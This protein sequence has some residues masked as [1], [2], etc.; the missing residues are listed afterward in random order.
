MRIIY[1]ATICFFGSIEC[2]NTL[3]KFLKLCK[4]SEPLDHEKNC[5]VYDEILSL[6]QNGA[7]AEIR[8]IVM[9]EE[10]CSRLCDKKYVRLDILIIALMVSDNSFYRRYF[11]IIKSLPQSAFE[12]CKNE[13]LTIKALE[14][15]IITANIFLKINSIKRLTETFLSLQQKADTAINSYKEALRRKADYFYIYLGLESVLYR[16]LNDPRDTLFCLQLTDEPRMFYKF[17]L[18]VKNHT[19]FIFECDVKRRVMMQE[20]IKKLLLQKYFTI[21]RSLN[22]VLRV[23]A[24]VNIKQRDEYSKMLNKYISI[25]NFS[26]EALE[27]C[28]NLKNDEKYDSQ[29]VLLVKIL[30]ENSDC[31]GLETFFQQY[32]EGLGLF[33]NLILEDQRLRAMIKNIIQ[34]HLEDN[35][36]I[37]IQYLLSKSS[38]LKEF[39]RN[40]HLDNILVNAVKNALINPNSH[41]IRS[42]LDMIDQSDPPSLNRIKGKLDCPR[43]FLNI[44]IVKVNIAERIRSLEAV[45]TNFPAFKSI[46]RS[47]FS[48]ADSDERLVSAAC[49]IILQCKIDDLK[50][51][52]EIFP[53]LEYI[54]EIE[55]KKSLIDGALALSMRK[56]IERQQ[57]R[58]LEELVEILPRTSKLA[59]DEEVNTHIVEGIFSL[60]FEKNTLNSLSHLISIIPEIS[61]L[62]N[63]IRISSFDVDGYLSSRINT[64]FNND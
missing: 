9:H 39:L 20:F 41:S 11:Q 55:N 52:L 46:L 4:E 21:D 40:E 15:E 50:C 49:Y 3:Y 17:Y 25:I 45:H 42:I 51:L 7:Y 57:F 2:S 31:V 33:D 14:Q 34:S 54:F 32:P 53:T 22:R 27:F 24:N 44:F 10:T 48:S 36:L 37:L 59:L 29:I 28:L 35:D 63:F 1:L 61:I 62:L 26:E 8:N 6:Y 23:C 43:E 58:L 64:L 16:I 18:R 19:Q 12:L 38:G 13:N 47:N 30:I 56:L 5:D 60:L